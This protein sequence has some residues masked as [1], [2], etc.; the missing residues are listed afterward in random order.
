MFIEYE[1]DFLK[2]LYEEGTCK[3]EKYRFDT[4][5]IKKYQTRIDTLMAA[6]RIEDLFVFHSLNFEAL[7]GRSHCFSIRIDSHY[8][9]EFRV[10]T[11]GNGPVAT[12]C[13]LT[14]ITDPHQ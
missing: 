5:V 12:I 11:E 10:R 9:L 1:K 8:R 7:Q 14:N 2:E 4:A 13:V 3:N 6:T